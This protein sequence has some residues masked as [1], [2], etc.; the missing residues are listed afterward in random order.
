MPS[1]DGDSESL[2]CIHITPALNEL[3][4]TFLENWSAFGL[5]FYYLLN[6][7]YASIYYFLT[8]DQF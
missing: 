2:I 3:K 1:K 7:G 6:T 4:R 5:Y 8:A